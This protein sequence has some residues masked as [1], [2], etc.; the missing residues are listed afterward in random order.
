MKVLALL[1]A[2]CIGA[3]LAGMPLLQRVR[4]AEHSGKL[5]ANRLWAA[6]R[7]KREK[8]LKF[9]KGRRVESVSYTRRIVTITFDTGPLMWISIEEAADGQPYLLVD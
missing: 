2:G 7:E 9:V 4:E 3:A 5:L 6:E 1:L 8:A